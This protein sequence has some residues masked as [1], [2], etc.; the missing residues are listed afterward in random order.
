MLKPLKHFTVECLDG[1]QVAPRRF[2]AVKAINH[3]IGASADHVECICLALSCPMLCST[4]CTAR[5]KLS[6]CRSITGRLLDCE[7]E[8]TRPAPAFPKE[9]PVWRSFTLVRSSFAGWQRVLKPQVRGNEIHDQLPITEPPR[10]VRGCSCMAL[11]SN[12][13]CRCRHWRR[14]IH[15]GLKI[16]CFC[17][18]GRARVAYGDD[19]CDGDACW[20]RCLWQSSGRGRER[21]RWRAW[22]PLAWKTPWLTKNKKSRKE[23]GEILWIYMSEP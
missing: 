4:V 18:H 20:V 19:A 8:S 21:N 11:R 3:I 12:C 15:R 17:A 5:S 23:R 22:R 1:N 13:Y 10:R 9:T 6:I 14:W 2:H 7:V 16:P